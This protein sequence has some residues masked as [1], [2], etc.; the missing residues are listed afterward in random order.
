MHGSNSS[1]VTVRC[2]W[3]FTARRRN[4]GGMNALVCICRSSVRCLHRRDAQISP[5]QAPKLNEM[6]RLRLR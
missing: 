3:R 4:S 5:T 1:W 6:L 2:A